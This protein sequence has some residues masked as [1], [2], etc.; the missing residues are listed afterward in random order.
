ML[1]IVNPVHEGISFK[2]CPSVDWLDLSPIAKKPL[3]CPEK[4][5]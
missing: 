1:G 5:R 3:R 2:H 4:L